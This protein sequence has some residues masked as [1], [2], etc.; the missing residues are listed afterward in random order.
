LCGLIGQILFFKK[1]V[2]FKRKWSPRLQILIGLLFILFVAGS[3]WQMAL[4][5]FGPMVTLITYFNIRNMK[6][7][8]ACGA[9]LIRGMWLPK[10]E[11]CSKCGARL[12]D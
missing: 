2:R 10:M 1:D 11:Y 7:C 9:T 4:F 12:A 6:F 5:F 8:D 3:S